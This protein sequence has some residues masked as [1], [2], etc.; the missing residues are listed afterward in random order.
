M[1]RQDQRLAEL[2]WR[3]CEFDLTRGDHGERVQLSS[4][5]SLKGVAGDITGGTFFL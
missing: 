2:L 5:L 4:G 1:I 3:V